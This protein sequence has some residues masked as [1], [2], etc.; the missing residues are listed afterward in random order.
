MIDTVTPEPRLTGKRVVITGGARG[1][2]GAIAHRFAVEGARVSILDRLAEEGAGLASSLGADFHEVDLLD[3][4]DAERATRAAVDGLGGVDVLVNSAGILRFTPLLELT[5]K[6]WNETFSINTRAMLTTMQ[7]CARSMI[8][9][10]TGGSIVNLASMAAKKG[11]AGEGAYPASKAAVVALTRT[12]ALEW[13]EHGIRANS[14]CPGYILTDMGA[15]TRTQEK[16]DLWSSY[17][18]L[19]RLGEPEDVA[20]VALFLASEDSRY[21]TGQAINVTGGMVMH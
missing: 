5:V 1:I 15:A 21:L 17:S 3:P 9:A 8:A 20:S 11:G 7:V 16:I 18:P 4:V 13:G 14:L 19:G 6:E 12:A 10:G 2:G